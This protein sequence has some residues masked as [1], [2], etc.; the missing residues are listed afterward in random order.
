MKTKI[1]EQCKNPFEPDQKHRKYCCEACKK[2][3]LEQRQREYRIKNT[4]IIRQ[5]AAAKYVR[6]I[7]LCEICGARLPHGRQK[8]CLDCLLKSY[9]GND[10]AKHR[11]ARN[12]LYCRGYDDEMI[13]CEC[14]ERG[15]I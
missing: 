1:C 11:R 2:A 15:I 4:D 8:I 9:K 7:A 6:A 3:G 12:I 10:K 13:K 5:K 14:E